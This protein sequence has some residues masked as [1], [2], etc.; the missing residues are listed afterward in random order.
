MQEQA[1]RPTSPNNIKF[2]SVE[3]SGKEFDYAKIFFVNLAL[4][5]VTFGFYGPWAKVRNKKYLYGMTS[6][7]GHNFDYHADPKKILKGRIIAFLVFG[8][9]SFL[10]KLS[11][12]FVAISTPLLMLASPFI[13]IQSL[14]FNFYNTSFRNIRF[15]H[16]GK[17][18]D[19]YMLVAKYLLLPILLMVFLPPLLIKALPKEFAGFTVAGGALIGLIYFLAIA[20]R[21]SNALFRF[22]YDNLYYGGMKAELNTTPK[23]FSKQVFTPFALASLGFGIGSAILVG[24]LSTL[25][26][27]GGIAGVIITYVGAF[28][29]SMV[30]PYLIFNFVWNNLHSDECVSRSGLE[31]KDFIT[32]ALT[33]AL[34]VAI[35][36]GLGYP[37]AKIRMARLKAKAKKIRADDLDGIAHKASEKESAI[38]EELGEF[39]DL[40]FDFGL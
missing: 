20:S 35:T 12:A 16:T 27:F 19:F 33:N 29:M 40:D 22:I 37:I 21:F 17:F 32:T 6:F 18:K 23:Q 1:A 38:G 8:A 39:F 9:V 34:I 5:I 36:L 3:F 25:G 13:I 11:P 24:L 14:K 15:H 2:E 4:T 10:G 31:F 30:L 7:Q 26:K 28:G